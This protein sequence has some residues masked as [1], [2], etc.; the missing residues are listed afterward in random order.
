MRRKKRQRALLQVCRSFPYFLTFKFS[1][2]AQRV[3]GLI[4][5]IPISEILP[6]FSQ[7]RHLKSSPSWLVA[8]SV[9]L[10]SGL[11]KWAAGA[12]RPA[13]AL[14]LPNPYSIQLTVMPQWLSSKSQKVGTLTTQYYTP[15]SQLLYLYL[16]YYYIFYFIGL[17]V[18]KVLREIFRMFIQR[19]TFPPTARNVLSTS[20]FWICFYYL[21]SWTTPAIS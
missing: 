3:F 9:V 8:L 14:M 16:Y 20:G 17:L 19:P 4:M 1:S 15:K 5:S 6:F 18:L 12:A 10:D 7:E 2:N 13:R 11:S 21:I